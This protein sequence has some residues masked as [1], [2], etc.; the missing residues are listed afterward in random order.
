MGWKYD[1][2]GKRQEKKLRK[3]GFRKEN[4]IWRRRIGS[5][6]AKQEPSKPAQEQKQR[7]VSEE[8]TIKPRP[9][10]SKGQML[11]TPGDTLPIV[12]GKRVNG[13]GGI[14]VQPPMLKQGQVNFVGTFLFP[15][16]EG[17]MDD[18]PE[19][20]RMYVGRRNV[21]FIT[22]DI[23]PT[24]NHYF[25]S[26]ADM[27]GSENVC[28]IASGTMFCS[29]DATYIYDYTTT[30]SGHTIS[31]DPLYNDLYISSR[32]KTLGIGDTSN[33][34]FRISGNDVQIL[35]VETGT[36]V[37][38][39][40]FAILGQ[41]QSTTTFTLNAVVVNGLIVG[42]RTVG[43]VFGESVG[44][45]SP[46]YSDDG[47]DFWDDIYGANGPVV[48]I[49]TSATLDKQANPSLPEDTGELQALETEIGY[50]LV[51]NPDQSSSWSGYDF[52]D[53]ADITFLQVT[54]DLYDEATGGGSYP[55]TIRQLAVYYEKG[56]KVETYSN[57][58]AQ[59]ARAS[60]QFVDLAMHLFS[61][62]KRSSATDSAF[63]SAVDTSNLQDLATFADNVSTH[64]NGV[65]QQ[66]VNVVNYV[67]KVAPFF[68]L[69]FISQNGQ[70]ALK[71]AIPLASNNIKTTA[72]T[73][74]ATFTEDDILPGSFKK[75]YFEAENR[76]DVNVSLIWRE[77][78]PAEIG[79]QRTTTVRYVT[80]PADAPSEQYDMT[81]FCT[82]INHAQLFGKYVLAQ[83]RHSTHNISFN[84]ALILTDLLPTQI[85]KVQRQRITSA[86]DN[87]TEIEWYQVTNIKHATDG[88]SYVEAIHF[89][90]DGSDIARISD[91]VVNGAFTVI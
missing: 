2:I 30:T 84:T 7:E 69:Q 39:S 28:P 5:E 11:L 8:R 24:A 57:G 29:I 35:E 66:S 79:V 54:G 15:I 89:P 9:D 37:T 82:S 27:A 43:T 3:M 68:L 80:T 65:I 75:T 41:S 17:E 13:N 50:S 76:R 86:G 31:Y 78:E 52:T 62:I 74:D 4:G 87:R 14:W 36:D 88:I 34:V 40:Y 19:T 53:F 47:S 91:D 56:I 16:S 38:S 42:G 61:L 70:Y 72:L 77:V 20:H 44:N 85:I 26:A 71:P 64:F 73:P 25:S 23:T 59:A 49:A 90:V 63:A 32:T 60:N 6:N 21:R 12:F 48:E 10:L 45:W 33:S 67:S 81:D 58:L 55:K 1:A 51:D 22:T 83:R 46:R 18:N